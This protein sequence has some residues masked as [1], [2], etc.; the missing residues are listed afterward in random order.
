[1]S[2]LGFES[3]I[4]SRAVGRFGVR[5]SNPVT[6]AAPYLRKEVRVSEKAS[7]RATGSLGWLDTD[8]SKS[9]GE[10]SGESTGH[11]SGRRIVDILGRR[12]DDLTDSHF[13]H[14][15]RVSGYIGRH[16]AQRPSGDI[17]ESAWRYSRM[18][19]GHDPLK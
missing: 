11:R 3:L 9:V 5:R 19:R 1:M 8:E 4:P 10:G 2:K 16:L 18:N 12:K 13:D 17:E 14:M 7:G 6:P 15:R